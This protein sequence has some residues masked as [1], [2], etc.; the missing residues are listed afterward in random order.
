MCYFL[1]L[2]YLKYQTKYA[3]SLHYLHRLI[4]ATLFQKLTLID[5]LGLTKKRLSKFKDDDPQLAFAF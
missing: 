5:L 1:M 3:R 2:A 4:K